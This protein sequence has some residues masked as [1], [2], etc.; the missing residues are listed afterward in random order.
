[1]TFFY[2]APV[3]PCRTIE[4]ENCLEVGV[5]DV[6]SIKQPICQSIN[7]I[8]QSINKSMK[9]ITDRSIASPFSQCIVDTSG[10]ADTI[11]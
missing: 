4:L 3:T 2:D 8:N 6:Q 9:P 1:M 10:D 11:I 5:T 7:Q